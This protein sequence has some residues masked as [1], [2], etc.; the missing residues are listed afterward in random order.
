MPLAITTLETL[1]IQEEMGQ[2]SY[3]ASIPSERVRM[4]AT[5]LV[6]KAKT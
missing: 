2:P 1:R 6:L 5:V 4:V 3:L